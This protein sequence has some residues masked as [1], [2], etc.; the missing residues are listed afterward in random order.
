VIPAEKGRNLYALLNSNLKQQRQRNVVLWINATAFVIGPAAL[1]AEYGFRTPPVHQGILHFCQILAAGLILATKIFT[2]ISQ[3][4]ETIYWRHAALDFI[5]LLLLI[6]TLLL[7]PKILDPPQSASAGQW[8]AFQVYL[9]ILMLVRGG[10]LS[11]S[12]AASGRAPT[13]ILLTSFT[14]IILIGSMLLM[15]P[16]AHEH[17]PLPFTDAV[18]T[19][20]SA[21]CVTGLIVRDTGGDFT[22][23]GQIIILVL[24]QIGG[25]GI[26]IFGSLFAILMG[27][28]LSLRESVAM[29]DIMNEQSAGRIGRIVVFICIFTLVLEGLGAAGLYG[30]WQTDPHRGG[31]LFQ[32]L[33][34]A[35]SAFCNAGFALQND[36][37]IPF[38]DCFRVYAIIG[39]L[40]IIG[41][42][43]FP[44]LD[45]LW[46]IFISR[47]RRRPGNR[48]L[49]APAAK[50][51]LHTK[52][53]LTSSAGLLIFGWILLSI[54]EWTR[55]D[56][57]KGNTNWFISLDALFNSITARTAGF[58]TVN[59]RDLSAGSKLMLIFLMS[60]GGSPSSTAGG[61]KT[62]TLVVMV[63][64]V[65]ATI[66]R[67]R[68][69]EIFH[70]TIPMM[71]VLRA[72]TLILLYGLLLWLMTLLLTIT[73]HSLGRDM[74]DLLFEAA[75][76]LGTVGLST[77]LT[78]H[79]TL[80]GKWVIIIAMFV[81]RLGPLSLLAALTFNT[82]PIRYQY[83]RE[84]LLVG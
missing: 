71:I 19:A 83:P 58:N 31:Q 42:L 16:A 18:F 53:V 41:G 38:R 60:V 21:T 7:L 35:I 33:F 43:G 49:K 56:M 25:L 46:S 44:V 10:R 3:K 37:L 5:L 80:A 27:S 61:I 39:P 55:P 8:G 79:L 34:H 20:T 23:L 4:K 29:S 32:S 6:T 28:R 17:A 26:M 12:A 51:N 82:P 77:G 15:L 2:W 30:L 45:N 75:S 22:R 64:A 76:A 40:I 36:S 24:I 54:L 67:R 1:I 14:S 52:I 63:L 68:T 69:I 65:Y 73:E 74:L 81:G 48:R 84:T 70:R 72:A 66:K 47:R 59:I 62:V 9:L 78:E 57:P 50:L 11:V 13:R